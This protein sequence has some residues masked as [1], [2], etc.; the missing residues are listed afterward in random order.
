M[1]HAGSAALHN[2]QARAKKIRIQRPNMMYK[3]CV[4]AAA[5]EYR[6]ENGTVRRVRKIKQPCKCSCSVCHTKCKYL[7]QNGA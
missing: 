7:R 6:A 5:A 4:A 3:E 1:S 2:I